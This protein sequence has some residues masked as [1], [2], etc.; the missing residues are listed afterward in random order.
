M[1]TQAE[2]KEEE[3]AYYGP[4]NTDPN[5]DPHNIMEMRRRSSFSLRVVADQ[6]KQLM[7][8]D[9]RGDSPLHIAVRRGLDLSVV[10]LLCRLGGPSLVMVPNNDGF[11][12]FHVLCSR[13]E[14]DGSYF[15]LVSSCLLEHGADVNR[16]YCL[17]RTLDAA[18]KYMTTTTTTTTTSKQQQQRRKFSTTDDDDHLPDKKERKKV[19]GTTT[20]T[21]T[22]SKSKPPLL[23]DMSSLSPA[24]VNRHM[25]ATSA[26]KLGVGG[27]LP[28]RCLHPA[29]IGTDDDCTRH[30][31]DNNPSSSLRMKESAKARGGGGGSKETTSVRSHVLVYGVT[32]AV[33]A[34]G[35]FQ[36]TNA[37][38]TFQDNNV[39]LCG[40]VAATRRT[41]AR[42]SFHGPTPLHC[43]IRRGNR[44]VVRYLLTVGAAQSLHSLEHYDTLNTTTTTFQE[45]QGLTPLE[46]AL[47]RQDSSRM[48]EEILSTVPLLVGGRRRPHATPPPNNNTGTE[49]APLPSS[50][51][52]EKTQQRAPAPHAQN[53]ETSSPQAAAADDDDSLKVD[54]MSVPWTALLF[55]NRMSFVLVK[56]VDRAI[57]EEVAKAALPQ[58]RKDV[59][60][61][62]HVQQDPSLL[63]LTFLGAF[64]RGLFALESSRAR[65]RPPT[66]GGARLQRRGS[67]DLS[68]FSSSL[69]SNTQ[70][71]TLRISIPVW[72][73]FP[74]QDRNVAVG[75]RTSLKNRHA[76]P[77]KH[78]L[79]IEVQHGDSLPRLVQ[80]K[81]VLL[82]HCFARRRRRRRHLNMAGYDDLGLMSSGA[83]LDFEFP[84]LEETSSREH[85]TEDTTATGHIFHITVQLDRLGTTSLERV[86]YGERTLQMGGSAMPRRRR[87]GG[88]GG[89]GGRGGGMDAGA[90]TFDQTWVAVV[91]PGGEGSAA[92]AAA[93]K[94]F[95][96]AAIITGGQ[97]VVDAR[98]E[99]ILLGNIRSL[100]RPNLL[101]R[102]LQQEAFG[103]ADLLKSVGVPLDAVFSADDNDGG[104]GVGVNNNHHDHYHDHDHDHA[105]VAV[106]RFASSSSTCLLKQGRLIDYVAST[107]KGPRAVKALQWLLA[108][109]A[110][111]RACRHRHRGHDLLEGRLHYHHHHLP[112]VLQGHGVG[113]GGGGGGV[114]LESSPL[115]LA[116]LQH[117]NG[118]V[119]IGWFLP[120]AVWSQ[121][122]H[123]LTNLSKTVGGGVMS[124]HT[125]SSSGRRRRLQSSAAANPG[126][127][128]GAENADETSE[129]K[130]GEM[131]NQWR[132]AA[133]DL[134]LRLEAA[135]KSCETIL[136]QQHRVGHEASLLDDCC[137]EEEGHGKG[138]GGGTIVSD[139]YLRNFKCQFLNKHVYDFKTTLRLHLYRLRLFKEGRTPP[140]PSSAG[141]SR[142][143]NGQLQRQRP[144]DHHRREQGIVNFLALKKQAAAARPGTIEEWRGGRQMQA[145]HTPPLPGICCPAK[146]WKGLT[147]R[148]RGSVDRFLGFL[149]THVPVFD[150]DRRQHHVFRRR[151]GGGGQDMGKFC[152]ALLA[153]GADVREGRLLVHKLPALYGGHSAVVSFSSTGISARY[154][155]S[156]AAS[157][158]GHHHHHHHSPVATSMQNPLTSPRKEDDPH[159]PLLEQGFQ[160]HPNIGVQ[161]VR[162]I[163]LAACL[164]LWD[165]VEL[166]LDKEH[167]DLPQSS[168]IQSSGIPLGGTLLPLLSPHP[169]ALAARAGQRSVAKRLVA[170]G[171]DPIIGIRPAALHRHWSTL[172]T[173]VA[174]VPHLDRWI[175]EQA[176]CVTTAAA[177][178][179]THHEEEEVVVRPTLTT[180]FPLPEVFAQSVVAA[181]VCASNGTEQTAQSVVHYCRHATFAGRSNGLS[182]DS[183]QLVW[184][185][186]IRAKGLSISRPAAETVDDDA[187]GDGDPQSPPQT[188]KE[189]RAAQETKEEQPNNHVKPLD[190]EEEG[191]GEGNNRKKQVIL[192][193]SARKQG[194][195]LFYEEPFLKRWESWASPNALFAARKFPS[196]AALPLSAS[197]P[198]EEEG[199]ACGGGG[200]G[201]DR[202]TSASEAEQLLCTLLI[203]VLNRKFKESVARC[204]LGRCQPQRPVAKYL[205]TVHGIKPENTIF[206]LGKSIFASLLDGLLT[207]YD[208]DD[209]DSRK[210]DAIGG[211]TTRTA[212]VVDDENDHHP[213]EEDRRRRRCLFPSVSMKTLLLDHGW[214]RQLYGDAIC[215]GIERRDLH[216]VRELVAF[217]KQSAAAAAKGGGGGTPLPFVSAAQEP[218]CWQ[219]EYDYTCMSVTTHKG[220]N[221]IERSS[222]DDVNCHH[223]HTRTT[224]SRQMFSYTLKPT[225]TTPLFFEVACCSKERRR[226]LGSCARRD[227]DDDDDDDD[228]GKDS[229]Q[230]ACSIGKYLLQEECGSANTLFCPEGF[231]GVSEDMCRILSPLSWAIKCENAA[232]VEMLL[233]HGADPLQPILLD[234]PWAS[235]IYPELP[236]PP[237]TTT[238][239]QLE[240][241]GHRATANP[242]GRSEMPHHHHL[243]HHHQQQQGGGGVGVDGEGVSSSS[244][245]P[246]KVKMLWQRASQGGGGQKKPKPPPLKRLYLPHELAIA[247]ASRKQKHAQ[248]HARVDELD[249]IVVALTTRLLSIDGREAWFVA[250][251]LRNH[252]SETVKTWV[253]KVVAT[254]TGGGTAAADH[255]DD[256]GDDDAAFKWEDNETLD[257]LLLRLA[258]S[259][260]WNGF[261][262]MIRSGVGVEA[263]LHR[264][265]H[266]QAMD[267]DQVRLQWSALALVCIQHGHVDALHA[268]LQ[269]YSSL[270]RRPPSSALHDVESD[271]SLLKN[272]SNPA[273]P[274]LLGSPH[275]CSIVE[276]P[277]RV[278]RGVASSSTTTQMVL[279][280]QLHQFVVHEDGQA[281]YAKAITE[282][283]DG[284]TTDTVLAVCCR[285]ARADILG[286]I[287]SPTSGI[288]IGCDHIVNGSLLQSAARGGCV[289]ILERLLAI[290]WHAAASSVST[291]KVP[292]LSLYFVFFLSASLLLFSVCLGLFTFF[293]RSA[294][295]LFSV[296]LVLFALICA[297]IP[298]LT[299]SR[300]A[301]FTPSFRSHPP[302]ALFLFLFV[303]VRLE[304]ERSTPKKLVGQLDL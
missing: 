85:R 50:A 73:I 42:F 126:V 31:N 113:V 45:G 147:D 90:P 264:R 34:E 131:Q 174:A 265:G 78:L 56:L 108:N 54:I 82:E 255:D 275:F 204:K 63:F 247:L 132:G 291:E 22:P 199:D 274:S 150:F 241:S 145:A 140:P 269:A 233:A 208:D 143:H 206:H 21:T 32:S 123:F 160:S 67:D 44:A 254:S 239:E 88:G 74:N 249:A 68:A 192:V 268:T 20:T 229:P 38:G 4:Q 87:R 55:R 300:S 244:S 130:S 62:G 106:P 213:T 227:D 92:A 1:Q 289:A 33:P 252:R 127:E 211:G 112:A 119:G 57:E 111:P 65:P 98:V 253:Q 260:L 294:C 270:R 188:T 23:F 81:H 19:P 224:T 52:K 304:S 99:A 7:C 28:I 139:E 13:S 27:S 171:S 220:H 297:S 37:Q 77:D 30:N 295:L 169:L 248:G 153:A 117:V 176:Q 46:S 266:Y 256:D 154:S 157:T 137:V 121:F 80:Q 83:F 250:S 165:I 134:I 219:H 183:I 303:S 273:R 285:R 207:P 168:V 103:V 222:T 301:L 14:G 258:T 290:L 184:K 118:R 234:T 201:G 93:G 299:L 18:H 51:R 217:W 148:V 155:S 48:L 120:P 271:S 59:V 282:R 278:T 262:K 152:H 292:V 298:F 84:N 76:K 288:E 146:Q 110:D 186:G 159:A 96:N 200:G 142:A 179:A 283:R 47:V 40:A 180:V 125:M 209:D 196:C 79:S 64:L 86:W 124:Q 151:C 9:K 181:A 105:A 24:A 141:I 35:T 60:E 246:M 167:V 97:S 75:T 261:L 8:R 225:F 286:F 237:T 195:G 91:A 296:C 100:L 214:G 89:E 156:T 276:G 3:E 182:Q 198:T 41:L 194:S 218:V 12:A 175:L 138:T 161:S 116:L 216:V 114:L 191:G 5:N 6:Q 170:L 259:G 263:N 133:A 70:Q 277:S 193:S 95:L 136:Q 279:F 189:N 245:T 205:T 107:L 26:R 149:R 236:P 302:P 29:F 177:A 287:V 226:R 166:I 251:S 267:M 281:G 162:S 215:S 230:H 58:Q 61:K 203:N 144:H 238:T 11:S 49:A 284:K 109:G 129:G 280:Q 243:H 293:C 232:A 94:V 190:V 39:I 223:H 242:T 16:T 163:E 104:V 71:L 128:Q 202:S 72:R 172:S 135:V 15:S 36:D 17:H 231:E 25:T 101:W 122:Q 10:E 2:T 115:F 257:N 212:V 102:C 178:A 240:D 43:A 197:P 228:D 69:T 173:L 185:E 272:N 164:G 187:D 158:E 210:N 221:A 53:L 66:T 235:D